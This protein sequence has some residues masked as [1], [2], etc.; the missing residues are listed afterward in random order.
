MTPKDIIA[1][2]AQAK[3]RAF[4]TRAKIS[5]T[6]ERPRMS[7]FRSLKHVSV[8]LIDDASGRTLAAASDMK[9][10]KKG[11]KAMD[12]AVAIGKEVAEKAKAAGISTVIFDRG[13]Y[14]YHGRV[15]ALADAAREGGL[16]F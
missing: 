5:G 8:Q 9:L 11:K 14:R 2:R 13:S 1:K 3:R 6:K 10:E 7:V 12:V 4:R 15:K 16:Q